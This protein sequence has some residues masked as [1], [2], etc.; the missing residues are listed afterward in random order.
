MPAP[1]VEPLSWRALEALRD[2][3]RSVTR[4]NGYHTDLGEGAILLD[5]TEADGDAGDVAVVFIDAADLDGIAGGRGHTSSDMALT[6]EFVVPRTQNANAKLQAHR[7]CADLVRV[8]TFKTGGRGAGLPPG[9]RSFE[10]TGARL[11]GYT[12]EEAGASFVI[13][14][15]T[16]RAGLT[17][18]QS[19]AT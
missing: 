9:F 15:V 8:L 14:Q 19:P 7:G 4:A 12:D 10:L 6:F 1:D 2:V 17:D 11:N 18:T 5:D 13:A 16:A 3:V